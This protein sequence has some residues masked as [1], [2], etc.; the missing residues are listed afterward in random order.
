MTL[1]CFNQLPLNFTYI[2]LT[3]NF[4]FGARVLS[5]DLITLVDN[6]LDSHSAI[7]PVLPI[8]LKY[9]YIG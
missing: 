9:L 3:V 8:Y 1:P 5:G 6:P 4:T 7:L 2:I